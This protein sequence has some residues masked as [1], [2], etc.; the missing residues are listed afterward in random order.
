MKYLF[1]NSIALFI[2]ILLRVI[3]QDAISG[4]GYK[5]NISMQ[6]LDTWN[7]GNKYCSDIMIIGSSI[8]IILGIILLCVGVKNIAIIFYIIIILFVL[9][10]ILTEI[11]L[12]KL[13]KNVSKS[14]DFMCPSCKKVFN[15]SPTRIFLTVHIYDEYYVKCPYCGKKDYMKRIINKYAR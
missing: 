12:R 2:F 10:C 13:F 7:E 3:K 5:S 11:H 6:N 15:A 4:I 1:I 8:S 9:S 14:Y